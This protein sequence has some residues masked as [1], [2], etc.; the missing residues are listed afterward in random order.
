MWNTCI[1]SLQ[2]C[3]KIGVKVDGEDGIK[4]SILCFKIREIMMFVYH[5]DGNSPVQRKSNAAVE[6]RIFLKQCPRVNKSRRNA[7]LWTDWF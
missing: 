4:I 5:A 1:I 2:I 3:T 7:M 6:R